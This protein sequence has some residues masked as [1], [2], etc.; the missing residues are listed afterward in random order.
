MRLLLRLALLLTVLVFALVS[1][2]PAGADSERRFRER[3]LELTNQYRAANGRP[4]L[5]LSE[6]LSKSAQEYALIMARQRFFGHDGP[7]GGTM[8]SRI[9]ASG[10]VG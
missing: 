6:Q 10:Y 9:E 1:T 2:L 7:N 5:F 8:V 4:P 3:L